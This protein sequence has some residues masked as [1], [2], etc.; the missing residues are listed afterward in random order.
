MCTRAIHLLELVCRYM[1]RQRCL[2]IPISKFISLCLSVSI[3][4]WDR[5]TTRDTATYVFPHVNTTIIEPV[6]GCSS[7]RFLLV[8]VCSSAVNYETRLESASCFTFVSIPLN[9]FHFQPSHTRDMGQRNRI[10]LLIFRQNACSFQ[11]HVSGHQIQ[12]LE[13]L[14]HLRHT[15]RF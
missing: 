1:R 7:K 8:I 15:K 11:W 5:N 12:G 3:S 2:P 6:N 9:K 10:Q 14:Q 13:K 4:G